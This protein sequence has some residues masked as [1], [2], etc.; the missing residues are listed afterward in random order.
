VVS[1]RMLWEAMTMV[2]WDIL[3]AIWVS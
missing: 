2:G 3:H 1:D